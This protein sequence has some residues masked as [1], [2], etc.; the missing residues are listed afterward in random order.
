M[1]LFAQSKTLLDCNQATSRLRKLNN[2]NARR[3][4][5]RWLNPGRTDQWWI[6]LWTGALGEEEWQLATLETSGSLGR[7]LFRKGFWDRYRGRDSS[8]VF[9]GKSLFRVRI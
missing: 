7:V 2:R 6:N 8:G 9:C 3:K 5:R 4:R 1:L